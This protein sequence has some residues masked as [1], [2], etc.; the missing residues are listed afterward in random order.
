[1]PLSYVFINKI[2]LCKIAIKLWKPHRAKALYII[3]RVRR[4]Q[5]RLFCFRGGLH[6]PRRWVLCGRR[7]VFWGSQVAAWDIPEQ[8]ALECL[9]VGLLGHILDLV[10]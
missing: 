8:L 2:S 1:M 5:R 7:R 9:S 6:R 4:T 3:L 10:V